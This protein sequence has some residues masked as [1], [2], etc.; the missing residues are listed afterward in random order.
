MVLV[1]YYKQVLVFEMYKPLAANSSSRARSLGWFVSQSTKIPPPFGSHSFCLRR[2]KSGMEAKYLCGYVYGRGFKCLDPLLELYLLF[3]LAAASVSQ[4]ALL[5]PYPVLSRHSEQ[6]RWATRRRS[7]LECKDTR[8][9]Q[10]A[11]LCSVSVFVSHSSCYI[12]NY[13][14]NVLCLLLSASL[15]VS[16]FRLCAQAGCK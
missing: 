5:T 12:S 11:S 15:A 16:L 10:D 4:R 9:S 7:I 1:L 14:A 6:W 2:A 8:K 13:T 3:S